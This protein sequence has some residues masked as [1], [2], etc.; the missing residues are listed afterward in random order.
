[1]PLSH[2]EISPID[3]RLPSCCFFLILAESRRLANGR[4]AVMRRP[5]AN[6]R[7]AP[8]LRNR[9][10][11]PAPAPAP[12][13]KVAAIDGHLELDTIVGVEWNI[14][15]SGPRPTILQNSSRS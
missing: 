14:S 12:S 8:V 10:Y 7:T 4:G 3:R 6:S 5:H 9:C 11:R 13:P 1:M 2:P 15:Q